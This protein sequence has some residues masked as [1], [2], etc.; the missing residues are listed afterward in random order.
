MPTSLRAILHHTDSKGPIISGGSVYSPIFCCLSTRG[1]DVRKVVKHYIVIL[2]KSDTRNGPKCTLFRSPYLVNL[3]TSTIFLGPR[4][5][6]GTHMD[7]LKQKI[8]N[9]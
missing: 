7:T 1:S 5:L 9:R 3:N 6:Q 2:V 4:G 8:Q